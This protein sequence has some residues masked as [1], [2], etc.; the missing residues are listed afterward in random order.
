MQASACPNT[1]T[2]ITARALRWSAA[3]TAYRGAL[4]K[5]ADAYCASSRDRAVQLNKRGK[6]DEAMVLLPRLRAHAFYFGRVESHC[7]GCENVFQARK[8]REWP[9]VFSDII[10][11]L[12]RNAQA[13]Y[14]LQMPF[15]SSRAV[16]TR[17]CSPCARPCRS[18]TRPMPG[19]AVYPRD[20]TF[21]EPD[22]EFD[23]ARLKL[24]E[25]DP[26]KRHSYYSLEEVGQ[27]LRCGT[28]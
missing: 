5:F 8:P 20:E 18:M 6:R 13:H 21:I 10:R 9:S 27:R 22:G 25:P 1:P 15:A 7:F 4:E 26:A 2:N 24:L 11:R 17:R 14:S 23:I 19:S 3:F 12:P 16:T 28:V